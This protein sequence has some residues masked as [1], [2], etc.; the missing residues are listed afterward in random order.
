MIPVGARLGFKPIGLS[1]VMPFLPFE[2]P[3][4]RVSK[5]RTDVID[6]LSVLIKLEGVAT[7]GLLVF[8][9]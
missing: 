9:S 7:G 3:T 8:G 5:L 2:E 6:G 4:A 1:R